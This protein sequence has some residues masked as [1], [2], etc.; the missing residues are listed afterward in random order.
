[1][2]Q[3]RKFVTFTPDGANNFRFGGI[4]FDFDSQAVD[5]RINGVLVAFVLIAPDLFQQRQTGEYF[6]WMAG[7]KPE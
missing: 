6:A 4:F 3:L 1:M 7:K 2:V 5:V